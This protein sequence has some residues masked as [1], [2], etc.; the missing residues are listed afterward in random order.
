MDGADVIDGFPSAS[1]SPDGS[2]IAFSRRDFERKRTF[3]IWLVN[4]NGESPHRDSCFLRG[5][6]ELLWAGL[7]IM[8]ANVSF[9]FTISKRWK[10]VICAERRSLP[11]SFKGNKFVAIC[12]APEGRLLFALDEFEGWGLYAYGQSMGD[13]GRYGNG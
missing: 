10:A 9:T 6:P 11:S 3:D 13:Q 1:V 7:V 8:M 12:F 5:R 2:L 4:A